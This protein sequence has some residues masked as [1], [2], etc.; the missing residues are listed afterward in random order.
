[1]TKDEFNLT[2]LV[3]GFKKTDFPHNEG[4]NIYTNGQLAVHMEHIMQHAILGTLPRV[5]GYVAVVNAVKRYDYNSPPP[6]VR[7]KPKINF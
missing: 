7:A 6:V 5:R 3:M 4:F 2:M 1:M